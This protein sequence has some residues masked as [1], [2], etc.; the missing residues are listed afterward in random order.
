M[1]RREFAARELADFRG[2][3]VQGDVPGFIHGVQGR[4]QHDGTL[5]REVIVDAVGVD[6]HGLIDAAAGVDGHIA[7]HVDAGDVSR[8]AFGRGVGG[9][10]GGG[11]LALGGAEGDHALGVEFHGWFAVAGIVEE[12]GIG[13]DAD[14]FVADGFG[15]DIVARDKHFRTRLGRFGGVGSD[16]DHA[17][18]RSSCELKITRPGDDAVVRPAGDPSGLQRGFGGGDRD[19]GDV[20][21]LRRAIQEFLPKLLAAPKDGVFF[22][23]FA[24]GCV[25]ELNGSGEARGDKQFI[26]RRRR[27]VDAAPLKDVNI[28]GK[29]DGHIPG[30]FARFPARR[31]PDRGLGGSQRTV[32]N[33]N[34]KMPGNE[35]ALFKIRL[36]DARV[37]GANEKR[38]RNGAR[39]SERGVNRGKDGSFAGIGRGECGRGAG[40]Q[41]RKV[42]SAAPRHRVFGNAMLP[43][44]GHGRS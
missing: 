28:P 26:A 34:L 44:I 15:A 41:D 3:H 32:A 1:F 14:D 2:S 18:V 6:S 29:I 9:R 23:S 11:G 43:C 30:R 37:V 4:V 27:G 24:H 22:F 25:G 33:V 38:H 8:Q 16:R 21:E 12:V 17:T 40:E 13:D 42:Q 35:H 20:H 31:K 36:P 10:G 5:G 19:F 7:F 39:R